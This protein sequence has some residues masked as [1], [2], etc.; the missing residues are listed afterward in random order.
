MAPVALLAALAIAAGGG[1]SPW[2][3]RPGGSGIAVR[4]A[5]VPGSIALEHI[6]LV[7]LRAQAAPAEAALPR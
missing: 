6:E 7:A 1:S 3:V 5:V 4:P 2:S